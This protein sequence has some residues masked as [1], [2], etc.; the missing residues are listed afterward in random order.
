MHTASSAARTKGAVRSASECT[1]TVAMPI[2]LAERMM[3]RAISPRLAISN[4]L[5]ECFLIFSTLAIRARRCEAAAFR[6]DGS[7]H[8]ALSEEKEHVPHAGP[9]HSAQLLPGSNAAV[10]ALAGASRGGG[11]SGTRGP[12]KKAGPHYLGSDPPAAE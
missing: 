12:K 5:M 7:R 6:R 11:R 9:A 3:R 10:P 8:P 1:A 2:S 4:F